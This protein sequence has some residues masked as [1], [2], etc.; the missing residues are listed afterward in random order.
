MTDKYGE[1]VKLCYDVIMNNKDVCFEEDNEPKIKELLS[2][3]G[4]KAED[5]GVFK[6]DDS[7]DNFINIVS[8]YIIMSNMKL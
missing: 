8:S 6:D 2:K 4:F 3:N 7:L 1:T 5:Y